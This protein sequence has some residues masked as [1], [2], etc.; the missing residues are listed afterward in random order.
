MKNLVVYYSLS[1]NTEAVAKEVARLTG[2]ELKKIEM[3]REPANGGIAWAACSSILGLNGKIK[4]FDFSDV[5][6][7]NMFIGG[8]VWAGH[9]ST[10]LNTILG[11][12]NFK[13][14]NVFVFLTHADDKC[15]EAV[16]KSIDGRIG[17]KGG[18]LVDTIYFQSHAK[19][20]IESS[21]VTQSLSE[22]IG[23]NS[24]M[25]KGI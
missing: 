1:G 22:W 3:E 5:D 24:G 4:P 13:D 18:N 11:K 2:G 15:P 10:P 19:T 25:I 17:K 23:R 12:L 21:D 7:D 20:V 14:K 9:S 6:Y 8:Q 16:L